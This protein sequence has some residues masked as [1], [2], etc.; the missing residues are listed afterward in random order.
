MHA[1]LYLKLLQNFI[2]LW[3]LLVWLYYESEIFMKL[4]IDDWDDDDNG[5]ASGYRS[6]QGRSGSGDKTSSYRGRDA[7]GWAKDSTSSREPKNGRQQNG[8]RRV[9]K[10]FFCFEGSYVLIKKSN[11]GSFTCPILH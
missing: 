4:T 2:F 10:L 8:E 11:Y 7:Y 1:V 3:P 9:V 5:Q 6:Y